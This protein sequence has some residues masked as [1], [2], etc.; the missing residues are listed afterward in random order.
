MPPWLRDA[1]NAT[2]QSLGNGEGYRYSHDYPE[3]IS[4]QDYML[5]PQAFYVP[6]QSGAEARTAQRLQQLR[7]LAEFEPKQLKNSKERLI[8]WSLRL[9]NCEI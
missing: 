9:H 3:S 8:F 1:H 2:N 5:D 6:G 4:G 7:V